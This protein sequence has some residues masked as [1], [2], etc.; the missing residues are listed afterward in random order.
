MC[1]IR[2]DDRKSVGTIQ[3]DHGGKPPKGSSAELSA[4]DLF[5]LNMALTSE[6]DNHKIDPLST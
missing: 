5:F 1:A 6:K 3:S 2:V 4:A